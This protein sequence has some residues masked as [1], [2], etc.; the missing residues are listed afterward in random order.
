M[1][2]QVKKEKNT[3]IKKIKNKKVTKMQNKKIKNREQRHNISHTARVSQNSMNSSK[4]LLS[5]LLKYRK[6]ENCK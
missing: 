5:H 2:T 1:N 3:R 4:K 6:R